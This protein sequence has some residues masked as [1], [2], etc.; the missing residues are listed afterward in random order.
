[1]AKTNEAKDEEEERRRERE[2]VWRTSFSQ[3]HEASK[4]RYT[5]SHSITRHHTASHS[6]TQHRDSVAQHPLSGTETNAREAA[7]RKAD[8]DKFKEDRAE[9]DAKKKATPQ[10]SQGLQCSGYGVD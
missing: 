5:A 2:A 6:I 7:Q 1:M 10:L 4:Q 3:H 8:D 9:R